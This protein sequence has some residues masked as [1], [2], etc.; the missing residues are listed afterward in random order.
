[1]S[2]TNKALVQRMV[3]VVQNQHQ[4]DR[5]ADF[6]APNFINHLDH[7][8]DAPLNSIEKAQQVFTQLFAAL[9]DLQVTI[10]QQVAEGDTVMTHK[11]F[12]GTH[13]GSF[14]GV[15]PSGKPITFSVIDILRLENDKIV[16]H[17][18]IQDRLGMMQQFGLL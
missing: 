10:Q 17:W 15:A 1:M 3:E 11:I 14:M 4:L 2:T 16:E 13:L 18:A 12:Q 6:F 5:M 9:P 7:A 8:P